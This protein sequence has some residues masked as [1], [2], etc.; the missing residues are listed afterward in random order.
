VALQSNSTPN[1]CTSD[2]ILGLPSQT[3]AV[4]GNVF[5]LAT[6]SVANANL[7]NVHVGTALTGSL[8]VAN[9]AANDGFS[10]NLDA[11]ISGTT[12]QVIASSGS[13][14][15][16]APGAT[17]G[18]G[19]HV[20]LDSSTAGA[21][22]GTATVQF[23]SNGIGI[24]GGAPIDNGS[25]TA[26]VT[27]GVYNLASSN[28]I[29]PINFGVLHVGDPAATRALTI[30]NTAP[31]GA[32]SEGL[33]SSFGS[34]ANNGGTLT[35]VFAGSITN[36]AAGA[37]DTTSMLATLS[38]ATAGSVN[39]NITI[40]QASN[41]TI[42]GLANT[43]LPDQAP[44]VTGTVSATITHLAVPQ[45]NNTQPLDFGN[46]R[47]G[48]A[49]PTQG[50]SVTNAA[51]DDGFSEGLIGAA[52]GAS[53]PR[54]TSAGGFGS[55]GAALA[56]QATNSGGIQIGIDASAA[57]AV[58]GNALID[59]KSDGTPFGGT[60]TDLGDT[61]VAV[62]ANVFRLASGSVATP[63]DIG[64]ARVGIGALSGHLSVTNSAVADGFSEKLD[65][66]VTATTFDVTGTTGAV[67]LLAAGAVP[68]T[69]IAVTLDN[70]TAGVKSGTA[71]VTF[72]SNGAGTDGGAPVD[73]GNQ[74][75]TVTGKVYTPAVAAM[76]TPPPVD[77]GIVHVGDGGG[78]LAR[79]VTVKN[80]A[81]ASAL[82]DV[83]V[84]AIAAGGAPFS[85][86]GNLG[87]GLGPQAQ[88]S[89]LQVA[90]GTGTAGI[91][92]GTAN[93][94]LSS[95]D[96][97]LADL[98]LATGPLALAAQVNRYAA[99]AFRKAGGDGGLAGGGASWTLD[100]GDVLQGS[101]SRLALLEF[102]NDN[103]LADQA[104][105]DLLSSAG[106]VLS[107]SGFTITGDSVGGLA[108]GLTQGGLD[109]GFATSALGHFA[110]LLSFDV[111]SSNAGGYDQVIGTVTLALEGDVV[112]SPPPGVPEPPSLPLLASGLGLLVLVLR[113]ERRP[114]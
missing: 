96:A 10:E 98:P 58:S 72:K 20:T 11:T 63:Q 105:T 70:S 44:A 42:S 87:S 48:S 85:A 83:M 94:A 59:F 47:I 57:G 56:P 75:A 80:D 89:A 27:G 51:P 82:N 30:A 33:D 45:I 86:S 12:P 3:V 38:T 66:A 31:A 7:G 68:S 114:G 67:G 81:A 64:A 91:F 14:A 40:H 18:S 55:P 90:L 53:S 6:G 92:S 109:I 107:G 79:S 69:A 22:S 111:E 32:F 62:K 13:V 21:K 99:L 104:F 39:G 23:K 29:A 46:V 17:N 100:F 77:F 78:S 9:T 26:T 106:S 76:L 2:C 93:L 65:A 4:K 36:L 101:P 49:V 19:L 35:P 52:N 41:G 113:R 34:Y 15:G 54:I 5:R 71:T 60:V 8:A 112:S 84:G 108:G 95:H 97:D 37:S 28:A 61:N 110:E 74:T 103:P 43:S 25:A 1:G 16:L 73:V 102:L 88:S 24:D 50:L